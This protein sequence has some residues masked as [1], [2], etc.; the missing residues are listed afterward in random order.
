MTS[1]NTQPISQDVLAEKYLAAG[2]QTAEDLFRRVSKALADQEKPELRAEWAEKFFQNMQAGAIGAGRI[3]AAAGLDTKA[4]LI[5]CFVQPVADA[6]N[7]FDEH[8]NPGIYTA[9]SQAAE[10]MRRG[11]GVGYDF[12]NLRPKGAKVKGTNSFASGP[13]SFID[14]FDAS[15]TTVESAG[16]RRGAQMGVMR[17]DHPDVL[18]FIT[19]KRQKGRWNN[20]NVSVGVTSAFMQAVESDAQWE[21]VHIATPSDNQIEEGAHQ[22]EDGK[23]VYRT[24][25]ARELWDTIM[26]SAYDFAEP[27]ILFIDNINTDNNLYYAETIAATNPCGEQPLPPYGCCDLGPIILTKF[28]RDAFTENAHFD[29]EAFRAAVSIQVRMLD[30]VLDAT[31]WPLPEQHKESQQKRRIGV[32]FTGLG[33]ALIML[34]L[35]YNS[36][37]GVAQGEEIARNMR[38]AA[39]LAS[40]ELAK[41]KGAFPLFDAD[42]YLQSG[43]TQRLPEE[44]RAAIRKHGIR[45]SHLLSIAPTGT[46]S[47]AFADNAS[48]G[49][50]P[51]FSWTYQRKKRTADGGN[52]FYTV[53]DHAYRLY[54]AKFGADAELPAYFVSAL[55]MT[56]AEHVAMM[57]AVQ[58]YIDTAISKTVNI[59]ADY[60]FEDFKNLYM[61]SWKAGLKGCATYRPNDTLGAVLSVEA[62]KT[63][64]KPAPQPAAAHT[65]GLSAVVERRP[66]G[67]LNAVVDKI[68]YYTHD[69]VRRL[70]LVV[71][72]M[73]VNG[74]ERP[75]EFFMPVGQTGE[76]QQWIT[77][78]MRSLSLAAR[79]GFLDKALDDLRK[80]AW[81]RGPI[82][83][84]WRDKEDGTRIP[85]W[86]DSEVALLAYAIQSIIANRASQE[87]QPAPINPAAPATVTAT[88]AA[89]TP[90]QAMSGTKCPECGAHAVIKKD[91]CSFCTSCGYIGACG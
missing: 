90:A 49:I 16:A 37:A 46:V 40:V 62:P 85:L 18:D 45:N 14:V 79:G 65:S 9:L 66:E 12:S 76:S 55:E 43:F 70:Y 51:P 20:F 52:A 54:K 59:P 4:T 69:G 31:V 60:P 44:I 73:Y 32:G 30:N 21:L 2:E 22:R 36:E 26:K 1:L 24:V 3:M 81:D 11:G 77:A 10:T 38:D 33:D 8:G 39:Y 61:E 6:T 27:G 87:Q 35:K 25:A 86:H 88:P 41:E 63:E 71:S 13:C 78:T 42:K 80:V 5:N 83:Y 7:G 58:P 91:G 53:E 57:R 29:F 50:E 75:I 23:W 72:F 17:I 15:C 74:V 67:P 82:R 84:G 89:A 68:E 64:E 28:V 19:A 56:A 48:N 34:G 47:L